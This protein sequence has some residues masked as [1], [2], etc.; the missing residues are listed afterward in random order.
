LFEIQTSSK[1]PNKPEK[2]PQPEPQCHA[3]QRAMS[4]EAFCGRYAVGRTL[5]YR[6][7][8]EGRLRARKIGRRTIIA[9]DDAENWL[10]SL[11]LLRANT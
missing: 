6:E 9:E 3:P 11:P 10:K 7:I 5:T 2:V 8:K 1:Q 4:V